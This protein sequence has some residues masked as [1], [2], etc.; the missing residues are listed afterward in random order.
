M[1][2]RAA[3][4]PLALEHRPAL[5]RS[6]FLVSPA[7]AAAVAALEGWRGW[8]DRRMALA[9]PARSGKTHLAHVWMQET[10]A[11]LFA[12]HDLDDPA[13]DRL[14][15][16]GRVVIE[17]ADA[18]GALDPGRRRVAEKALFHLWNLAAAGGCWLL[19]TGREAPGRWGVEMPDLRSRLAALPV[20]RLSPP[21]DTLLAAV[22]VKLFEDR[23]VQVGPGVIQYLA[24]RI[25][26]SFEGAEAAVAGLD[27]LSLARKRP[28]TRVLAAELLAAG[29]APGA[30]E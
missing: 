17:D 3:Q 21:D 10:G 4:I 29:A 23:Q 19:V 6:A 11:A 5:G 16:Q 9:G 18:L 13:A 2:G 12:A 30:T 26:R 22:M 25:E 15:R 24:Q 20:A 28:V 27:R 8:P 1:M 14:A 7:N